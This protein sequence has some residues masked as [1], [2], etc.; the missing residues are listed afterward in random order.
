MG[1]QVIHD[2]DGKL[3]QQILRLIERIYCKKYIGT[4]KVTHN[5]PTGITARF[6]ILTDEK[7]IYISADLD[8]NSFL[9]YIEK[10]LR[11][12][13]FDMVKFFVG[14]KESPYTCPVDRQCCKK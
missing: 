14:Y 11:L 2:I 8:D 7:P 4:L 9:K 12:R 1:G 3:Q 10:E 6:G 13:H 5:N